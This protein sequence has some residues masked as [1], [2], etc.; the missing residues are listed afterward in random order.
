MKKVTLANGCAI[1]HHQFCIYDSIPTRLQTNK[2]CTSAKVCSDSV[3]SKSH[4]TF[5]VY[6]LKV[7]DFDI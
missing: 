7:S 4:N 5:A 6:D 2:T 1:V 3:F